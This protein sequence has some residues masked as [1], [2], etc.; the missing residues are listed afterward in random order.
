MFDHET[1]GDFTLDMFKRYLFLFA[2]FACIL[3]LLA[4][5][6]DDEVPRIYGGKMHTGEYFGFAVALDLWGVEASNG[7][8]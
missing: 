8:W 4:Y 2:S 1:F 5:N 3:Q 6:L 7:E